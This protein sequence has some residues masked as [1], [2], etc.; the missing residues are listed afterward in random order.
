MAPA[1][2]RPTRREALHRLGASTILAAG[3]LS[4]SSAARS[5]TFPSKA[6]IRTILADL[7]PGA[8]AS[9]A[10]LF[11]EHMS[12]SSEFMG[13]LVPLM[14]PQRA[15]NAGGPQPPRPGEKYFLEDLDLMVDELS[16]ARK[17]GVVCLVDARG[18]RIWVR[19][20]SATR[21]LPNKFSPCRLPP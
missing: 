1:P 21:E 9:G 16:A 20:S 14:F 3:A 12:F 10:T 5:A 2:A 13:K 4:A 18:I 6:I 15:A 11:H 8:L 19:A 7:P 17:D